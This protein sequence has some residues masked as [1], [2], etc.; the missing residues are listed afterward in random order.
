M[1]PYYG[2]AAAAPLSLSNYCTFFPGAG[3]LGYTLLEDRRLGQ[4]RLVSSFLENITWIP[5][6]LVRQLI[7]SVS[8]RISHERWPPRRARHL[9]FLRWPVDSSVPG[10]PRTPLLVQHY[11]GRDE[12]KGRTAQLHRGPA[13]AAP[14]LAGARHQLSHVRDERCVLDQP[15]APWVADPGHRLGRYLPLAAV[16]GSHILYPIVLNP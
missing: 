8:N 2:L 11:L 1:F 3:N 9:L 5:F 13:H 7:A 6:L 12:E 10:T 15:C 4:R 14:F 16:A